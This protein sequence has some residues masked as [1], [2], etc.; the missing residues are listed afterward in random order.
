MQDTLRSMRT[1]ENL[2]NDL[3]EL[4]V[5]YQYNRL[6]LVKYLKNKYQFDLKETKELVDLYYLTL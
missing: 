4:G 3:T 2:A 6:Q 5:A 1:K